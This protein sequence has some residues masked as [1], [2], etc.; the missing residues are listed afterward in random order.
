M[1]SQC[2]H[3]KAMKT[4]INKVLNVLLRV[5]IRGTTQLATV[6]TKTRRT[7][8]T[9]SKMLMNFPRRF[10]AVAFSSPSNCTTCCCCCCSSILEMR[11]WHASSASCGQE[12][13]L[14]YSSSQLLPHQ[15]GQV[16]TIPM[17]HS[18]HALSSCPE[19]EQRKQCH[20]PYLWWEAPCWLGT[21]ACN[22]PQCLIYTQ[23]AWH[24]GAR[25][26]N[27]TASARR[28]L[29]RHLGT[30]ALVPKG[31]SEDRGTVPSQKSSSSS[32]MCI[33]R[34]STSITFLGVTCTYL[35]PLQ[36]T[37]QR[38]RKLHQQK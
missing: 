15:L 26:G 17:P 32:G 13:M 11:V 38:H 10:L 2:F 22:I 31:H 29:P 33:P 19:Q 37:R 21:A 3:K 36:K 16:R 7:A 5:F 25:L 24:G 27:P 8:M 4:T 1:A 12:H 20:F 14:G 6:D 23:K 34:T 35:T 28:T 18:V 9:A 30:S